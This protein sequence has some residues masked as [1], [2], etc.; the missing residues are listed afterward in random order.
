[1]ATIYGTENSEILNG[2][3][4]AD[5]ISGGG[6]NDTLNGNAA[7]DTLNGDAGNDSLVGST[8]A[9]ILD[10]GSGA[11]TLSGGIGNDSLYADD[12]ADRGIGGDGTDFYYLDVS[13]S[14]TNLSV[15]VG[16]AA[17]TVNG[18]QVANTVELVSLVLGSGNDT[19]NAGALMSAADG[20]GGYLDGGLGTDTLI[21]DYSIPSMLGL[22]ATQVSVYAPSE[23]TV[24][25]AGGLT[26][27]IALNGFERAQIT[28][29][30]GADYL[31]SALGDTTLSGGAGYDSLYSYSGNDLLD[32]GSGDD[33]VDVRSYSGGADTLSGGIGNDSLYADDLADRGI[34]GDG[35]DLYSLTLTGVTSSLSVVLAG[36]AVTVNGTQVA[37]TIELVSLQLGSGNDTVNAGAFISDADGTGGYLDA[38]LGTDTLILDYSIP[39]MLGASA[40]W[41]SINATGSGTVGLAGGETRT[42]SLYGFERAQITGTAGDDYLYGASSVSTLTGGAG[43]DTLDGSDGNDVLDGGSGDDFISGAGGIDTMSGGIGNDSLYARELGDRVIGGDGTDFYNLDIFESTTNLSVVLAGAAVTVNGTQVANTVEV[44]SLRPAD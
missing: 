18:T 14:T 37:N 12:L 19:V 21:L 29:T 32:G 30:A 43:N 39:S 6:G 7:N 16:G 36:A 10:G 5:F 40:A 25:L 15:V 20:T 3:T 11:D 41:V 2:G 44:V 28:G 27:S 22:S 31:F 38:G 33:V 42:L 34:G 1:M 9:D 17:L 23:V 4:G 35:V 13:G 24:T 26:R 8:G